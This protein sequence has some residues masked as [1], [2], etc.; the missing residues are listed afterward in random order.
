MLELYPKII[1]SVEYYQSSRYV[2]IFNRIEQ[3]EKTVD[4]HHFAQSEREVEIRELLKE[5]NEIQGHHTSSVHVSSIDVSYLFT[6]SANLENK[7]IENN[8]ASHQ[9]LNALFNGLEIRIRE[10]NSTIGEIDA[11]LKN[12]RECNYMGESSYS[13]LMDKRNK[14]ENSLLVLRQAHEKQKTIVPDY[15]SSHYYSTNYHNPDSNQNEILNVKLFEYFLVYL[16]DILQENIPLNTAISELKYMRVEF[17]NLQYKLIEQQR[18]IEMLEKWTIPDTKDSLL[19][20][21]QRYTSSPV[22]TT[23]KVHR[24]TQTQQSDETTSNVKGNECAIG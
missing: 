24:S 18:K 3:L 16:K 21:V 13:E 2:E 17:E 11:K 9:L 8:M 4:T 10:L 6:R 15:Y 7:I 22:Q 19:T 5:L 14:Y 23:Y 12:Y 20:S 1:E